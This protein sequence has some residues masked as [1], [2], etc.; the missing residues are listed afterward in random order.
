MIENII[1][2]GIAL[3]SGWYI[4]NYLFNSISNNKNK[5]VSLVCKGCINCSSNSCL[6]GTSSEKLT[7]FYKK[8][9]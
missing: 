4:Y 6:G 2:I 5:D 1:L 9:G 3:I 7:N 8:N